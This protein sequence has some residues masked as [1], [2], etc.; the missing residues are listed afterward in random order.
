LLQERVDITTIVQPLCHTCYVTKA[1]RNLTP[2]E[3]ALRYYS[4]VPLSE[5]TNGP[6]GPLYSD[7]LEEEYIEEQVFRKEGKWWEV[8]LL[9]GD[10]E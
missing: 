4:G 10:N 1:I 5:R 7:E 8:D 3:Y 2:E 9:G 6:P